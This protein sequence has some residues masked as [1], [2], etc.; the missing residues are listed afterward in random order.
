[1]AVVGSGSIASRLVVDRTALWTIPDRADGADPSAAALGALVRLDAWHDNLLAAARRDPGLLDATFARLAAEGDASVEPKP[2][3]GA[4]GS[5][6]TGPAALDVGGSDAPITETV[7]AWTADGS[8]TYLV[9]GDTNDEESLAA[10][11][12]AIDWLLER[13]ATR[14]VTA[15]PSGAPPG[16]DDRAAAADHAELDIADPTAL[17]ALVT[18]V[19]TV[20]NPL[21]G[22][23][24]VPRQPVTADRLDR[25]TA[26]LALSLYV[27][28]GSVTDVFLPGVGTPADDPSSVR[29][30]ITERGAAAGWAAAAIARHRSAAGTNAHHLAI[31]PLASPH[32]IGVDPRLVGR[33]LD[34]L[35]SS[36]IPAAAYDARGWAQAMGQAG[37]AT[38]LPWLAGLAHQASAPGETAGASLAVTLAATPDHA[39]RDLIAGVLAGDIAAILGVDPD[40]LDA[41]MP[42]D[43]YGVDSLVGMELRTR[44]ETK[45]GYTVPLTELSRSMTTNALADHL[46]DEAVPALLIGSAST[47]SGGTNEAP[48][49]GTPPEGSTP[50]GSTAEPVAPASVEGSATTVPVRHG[51]G[52][53]TW[54]VPGMFGTPETFTPLGAAL[55]G[56]DVWAFRAPEPAPITSVTQLAE[57]NVAALRARRPSGPY[58]IGGYSLGALVAAEMTTQLEAAG[59]RVE[60]LWLLDPPPPVDAPD[61]N[62]PERVAALLCDHLNELFFGP[63]ATGPPLEVTE[64]PDPGIDVDLD[65]VVVRVTRDGTTALDQRRLRQL[66]AR[67]WG[68][69]GASLEAMAKYRP[70][71]VMTAPGTVVL[72]TSGAPHAASAGAWVGRFATPPTVATIDTD[73]AGLLRE[74]HAAAVAAIVS[75]SLARPPHHDRPIPAPEATM[76]QNPAGPSAPRRIADRLAAN[77]RVRDAV[78]AAGNLYSRADF[79]LRALGG[80]RRFRRLCDAG[81]GLIV[82][83]RGQIANL[84]GDPARVRLGHHCLVDGFINVQEYAYLSIGSYCGIGVDARIDCAGYVEI[85]N[86]CT[87]AEGVYIID[88]LHHPLLVN[89]RIEHGVDLFEGSHVMDAYG[90]GTQTSFVRIEDLVWIGLRAVVLSGVT[91]GR[92]SVVAAGAVVSQDVPPFSVVAGNPGQVIGQIPADDFDLQ[93][94]PTYR[95]HRGDEPLPDTRRTPRE[96]LD[97]IA[98]KVAARPG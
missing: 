60:Q 53:T 49:L 45:F 91:I 63:G 61:Q 81:E 8:A 57:A 5:A 92:G 32:P 30:A 77:T 98:G 96:V 54:W 79:F 1:M 74:P 18:E 64:L 46:L 12:F 33:V 59:D 40:D 23:I 35:V 80:E 56:H 14:V 94:H 72:A 20:R 58:R 11:R 19:D 67:L 82:G 28:V 78:G 3:S 17:A 97:E 42:V 6:P 65:A 83:D 2:L 43:T 25:A 75:R 66:F 95:A 71:A 47:R 4:I 15:S 44:I 34:R 37:E 93:S 69:A 48:P 85:G 24:W 31:G 29:D 7:D 68:M 13:G 27:T 50:E 87:L 90:P 21:A 88:G 9:G 55:D 52:P 41:D 39:R 16:A 10:R 51:P 84:S 62:R 22:V 26:H 73:H 70:G 38:Q 36:D 76:S 89:E 86:G